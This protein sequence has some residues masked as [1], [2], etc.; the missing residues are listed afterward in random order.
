MT[1]LNPGRRI[2]TDGVLRCPQCREVSYR[3]FR[4]QHQQLDG[5]LL[6]AYETVLWPAHPNVPPPQHPEKIQCPDCRE[7]LKREAG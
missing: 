1:H 2:E 7:E 4:R 6:P 3:I 5:T